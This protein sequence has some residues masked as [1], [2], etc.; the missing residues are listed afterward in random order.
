MRR[1]FLLSILG[2]IFVFVLPVLAGSDDSD[3][4]SI[5][6]KP[7]RMTSLTPFGGQI[8]RVDTMAKSVIVRLAKGSPIEI[9]ATED[10]RVRSLH[11]KLGYDA[12]GNVKK[13]PSRKELNE[14][15]GPEKNLPGYVA[16]WE[17]LKGNQYVKVYVDRRTKIRDK[18]DLPNRKAGK[19]V[20][21]EDLKHI[22]PKKIA[23]VMIVIER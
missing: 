18:D 3:E 11:P 10:L 17:D 21:P 5:A 1:A 12:K 13:N 4:K 23:A 7:I 14:L 2:G 19:N 9:E 6:R 8:V 20:T 15:R 16:E 22:P